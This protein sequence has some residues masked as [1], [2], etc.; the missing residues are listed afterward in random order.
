LPKVLAETE[1][2]VLRSLKESDLPRLAKLLDVWEVVRWLVVVPYP[3]TLH[4]ARDFFA[5]INECHGEGKEQFF[6]L[7][8]K[9]DDRLIGGVGLHPPRAIDH[10]DGDVE[11]GYWLGLDYWGRGLI[12]EAAK[13]VRDIGFSWPSTKALVS[14]TDPKNM[15]SQRVLTKLG[16]RNLGL[17]ERTYPTLR[18]GD[19]VVKWRLTREERERMDSG[20]GIQDSGKE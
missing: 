11:I 19:E 10:D 3:Y 15:A 20:F 6:A 13:R 8:F 1:R 14:T 2:L 16:L 12:T 7:S 4:D 9:D 18:G 5:E 17:V